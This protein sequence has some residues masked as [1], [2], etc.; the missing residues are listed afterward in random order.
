MK[1]AMG[2][3]FTYE[4]DKFLRELTMA[5]TT[6]SVPFGGRYRI[7]D[8][9]LS[10][11]VNSGV[12]NVGIITKNNYHSLMDHLGTGKEWDLSRKRDGL[13]I[14]P[15]FASEEGRGWYNGNIEALYSILTYIKRSKEDYVIISGSGLVCNMRYDEAL[16]FHEEKGADITVIYN[17]TLAENYDF[18]TGD[19]IVQITEG[20]R[21]TDIAFRPMNNSIIKLSM[22]KYIID[23]R[24]LEYLITEAV[25]HSRFDFEK[26]IL[27]RKI[28]ELKIYGHKYD[29]Y[30][31]RINSIKSY[32]KHSMEILDME[33]R[34]KLFCIS[35]PIYTK[36]KDEVPC[37]YGGITRVA[38]SLLADGCIID[39]EV[40][41]CVIFRGVKVRRGAKL[42][43]CIVMQDSDIME[44]SVISNAILD[45]NVIIREGRMLMG[46]ENY[47][48]VLSKG[49][50]V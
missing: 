2:V 14:L 45:K 50:I 43:N 25:A 41:N 23:K 10:N 35:N 48:V 29:G 16:E 40:D 36:V 22:G 47:P 33:V 5:R 39:G 21:I 7:I 3:V 38:N 46:H 28:S 32:Y 6:A 9:I 49:I 18:V 30:A 13:F 11:L 1:R 19:A 15:P 4:N 37:M 34:E 17:E 42:K 20:G 26:D 24:L 8:F 27:Q 12:T 44:N 31:A